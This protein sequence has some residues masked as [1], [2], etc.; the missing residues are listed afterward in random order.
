[1]AGGGGGIPIIE[2]DG[3]YRGVEAVIDKDYTA[4][5]LAMRLKIQEL[6]ICT[7]VDQVYLHYG[8]PEQEALGTVDLVSAKAYL[9]EGHFPP[10]SMGP[11]VEALIQFI[12][13]GGER[14][15]LTRLESLSKA[16]IGK[17]GTRFVRASEGQDA[18][19]AM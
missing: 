10:G 9:A 15:T 5:M 6:L 2:E 13:Q 8:T 16:L 7:A 17:A 14:A 19:L 3:V 11:K 12:E 1:M 18:Q 4:C